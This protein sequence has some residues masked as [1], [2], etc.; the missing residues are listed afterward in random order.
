MLEEVKRQLNITW[1]DEDIDNK[2]QDLIRQSQKAIQTLTGTEINFEENEDAKELLINR[3][4]YAYNNAIEYF[5]QNFHGEIL[6][7]QLIEGVK[8]LE[9]EN[10]KP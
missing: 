10:T 2:L 3:I 1:Q 7:L 5:E 8:T 4:R 6:R 9:R